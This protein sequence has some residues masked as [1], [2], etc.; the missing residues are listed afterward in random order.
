[1]DSGPLWYNIFMHDDTHNHPRGIIKTTQG[2]I[3][4][5]LVGLAGVFVSEFMK[6]WDTNVLITTVDNIAGVR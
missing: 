3:E 6:L 1:M 2:F 5:L 4:I